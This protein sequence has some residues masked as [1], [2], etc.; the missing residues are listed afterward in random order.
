MSGGKSSGKADAGPMLEYGNKALAL[1]QSI[2][3]DTKT[4]NQPYQDAGYAGLNALMM[5]LG[6]GN[7]TATG[8][9]TAAQLREEYL[10]SYT[11]QP[12]ASASNYYVGPDGRL[13]DANDKMSFYGEGANFKPVGNMYTTKELAAMSPADRGNAFLQMG[14]KQYS[15][16]QAATVD[17]AGLDAA[18][19]KALDAQSASAS[20]AQSN[21]LYGSLLKSFSMDDYTADPGYQ[22]RLSEGTKALD[23]SLAASGQYMTP[24]RQK[25]L[26]NYNQGMA[27]EEY[28]NAY[29][30]YNIDQDNIFNRL[31]AIA[32]VGQT[33]NSQ[34]AATGQNYANSATDLYTGMG[35][36][37]VSANTANQANK[38]SMFKTLLSAGAQLGSSYLMS[39]MRAKENITKIGTEN[40][41]NVY[42]YNYIGSNTPFVGV[43]AQE[44]MKTRP[45]AVGIMNNGYLGVDY[46]AIG[47]EF[48]SV[49]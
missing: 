46:K 45:D 18:V 19:Q 6:L 21:P 25:A 47:V 7:G 23:R 39:D 8:N 38:S 29:N 11:T 14:Y 9:K 10:P 15:T 30:R 32:G 2:Y 44:V 49:H 3:D 20:E 24:E 22:F 16:P 4:A 48:R 1:Q 12:A 28:G 33:A 34:A 43:I 42:R 35:N 5:R 17:N 13:V 27:S 41:H 40:G 36:S 37:I 31:A 26:M